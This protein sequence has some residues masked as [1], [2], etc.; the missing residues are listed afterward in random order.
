MLNYSEV[1]LLILDCDG[2]LSDGKIIYSEDNIESKT[3]STKDG[4]GLSLLKFSNIKVA[5]ITGRSSKA[6]ARRCE[7]LRIDFLYQG[8]QNKIAVAQ[9]IID[10]LSIQWSNVAFM[11]DDLNDYLLLQKVAFPATTTAAPKRIKRIVDFISTEPGGNGAV[12]EYIEYIL[13]KQEIFDDVIERYL[14]H[15]AAKNVVID[16]PSYQ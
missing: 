3:F 11:G 7:E 5:V 9:N 16:Q 2:V 8:I 6:L 15:L 13:T 4:L 12:R 10:S 1:K 14:A